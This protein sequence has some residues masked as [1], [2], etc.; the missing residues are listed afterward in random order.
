MPIGL[1]AVVFHRIMGNSVDPS[2]NAPLLRI[3]KLYIFQ[4]HNKHFCRSIFRVLSVQK[5]AECIVV[6]A[7]VIFLIYSGKQKVVLWHLNLI[8]FSRT[9]SVKRG[10]WIF[11]QLIKIGLCLF[12]SQLLYKSII[13][14]K[15]MM[16]AYA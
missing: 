16:A 10:T 5:P 6:N 4:Q 9:C 13:A 8:I 7:A 1:A 14:S 12:C 11:W 2:G 3:I 15:L